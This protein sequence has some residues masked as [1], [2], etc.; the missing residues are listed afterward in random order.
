MKLILLALILGPFF[1]GCS[2]VPVDDPKKMAEQVYKK[3]LKVIIDGVTYQGLGV[4][5]VKSSYEIVIA[6]EVKCQRITIQT[7]NR[8]V[9]LDEPKTGW[10]SNKVTYRY[11]PLLSAETDDNSSLE[12]SCTNDKKKNAFAY[13]V[14]QDSRPEISLRAHMRCNGEYSTPSGVGVCQ[15]AVGLRQEIFFQS[16]VVAEDIGDGCDFVKTKDGYFWEW[17]AIPGEC[18]VDFTSATERHANGK[19]LSFRLTAIGYTAIPSKE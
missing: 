2:S 12:I 11:T 13:L 17:I 15:T 16:R 3:D 14:F 18:E 6:P 9:N 19:R 8:D 4:L 7:K 1:I 5:P 10:L